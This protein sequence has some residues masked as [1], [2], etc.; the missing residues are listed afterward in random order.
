[1]T[2]RSAVVAVSGSTAGSMANPLSVGT[3]PARTAGSH[4]SS[5]CRITDAPG[6]RARTSATCPVTPSASEAVRSRTAP[7]SRS[8]RPPTGRS[9]SAARVHGPAAC[10]L[11]GP[12]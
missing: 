11:N 7:A 6:T 9:I 5:S 8:I 1:M 4:G 12:T 10:T 3:R 2:S